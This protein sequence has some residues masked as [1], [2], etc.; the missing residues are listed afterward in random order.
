M[1]TDP[2]HRPPRIEGDAGGVPRTTGKGLVVA[3]TGVEGTGREYA[4]ALS[5]PFSTVADRT[6]WSRSVEGIAAAHDSALVLLPE[7]EFDFSTANALMRDGV[8]YRLPIGVLPVPGESRAA[9]DLT[10][11]AV[12]HWR[13][14]DHSAHRL[15]LYCDFRSEPPTR[16]AWAFGSA[17]SDEFVERLRTGVEAVVLHSHGNGADFRV[18]K[19]VLC[20]QADSSRPARGRSGER[21]LPCQGGGPCRLEHRT[22]FTA[23]HGVGAVRARLVVVLSCSAFQP[24]DGMLQPRFQFAGGMLSR[25]GHAAGLVA[26]TR[27]NHQTPRLG[28]AVARLL[29]DGAPLGEVAMRINLLSSA[30]PSYLCVGDPDLSLTAVEPE[31]S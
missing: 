30:P 24:A 15:A 22:E 23:F 9:R 28:V 6:Q 31:P 16:T 10:T 18:G 27:I 26:S 2:S 19:H 21:F 7:D 13:R 3:W 14:P 8:T 25:A 29:D 17:G 12:E 1:M 4:V 20:H 11:R 5:R